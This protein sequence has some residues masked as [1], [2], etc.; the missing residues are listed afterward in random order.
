[1]ANLKLVML[2]ALL[3]A[4]QPQLTQA[5]CGELVIL[6]D[7]FA[8]LF[9]SLPRQV[10][11]DADC[12]CVNLP[13]YYYLQLLT[14]TLRLGYDSAFEDYRFWTVISIFFSMPL[15]WARRTIDE[16]RTEM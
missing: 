14:S 7:N 10:W 12:R 16:L 2:T 1:M 15:L 6:L 5:I 3:R 4:S 9:L 11:D 13:A 8:F